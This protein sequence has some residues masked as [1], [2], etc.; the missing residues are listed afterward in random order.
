MRRESVKRGNV[1]EKEENTKD[2][3]EIWKLKVYSYNK[4]KK[5]RNKVKNNARLVNFRISLE[6]GK[7]SSF[8][9]GGE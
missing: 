6:R 1:K 7:I 9:G 2:K 4:S 3:G 5:A 8:G